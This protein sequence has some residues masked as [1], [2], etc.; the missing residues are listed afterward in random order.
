MPACADEGILI[1][2]GR[3]LCMGA[4]VVVV[5][6]PAAALAWDRAMCIAAGMVP[7]LYM[8]LGTS[9]CWIRL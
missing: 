4:V 8:G 9:P 1:P 3:E 2:V 7:W 6:I 5:A